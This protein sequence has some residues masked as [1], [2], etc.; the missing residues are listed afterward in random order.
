MDT[1]RSLHRK[2]NASAVVLVELG[3]GTQVWP[4]LASQADPSL[5]T[6]LI[7]QFG[8]SQVNPLILI[9]ELTIAEDDSIRQALILALGEYKTDILAPG[10]HLALIQKLL[11]LYREDPGP[12]THSAAEWLLRRWGK[13]EERKQIDAKM[14]S[15]GP[16]SGFQ[17][18]VN[19]HGQ[20]MVI[21]RGPV[22]RSFGGKEDTREVRIP[23]SF[24]LATKEVTR[25]QYGQYLNATAAG[26]SE[27]GRGDRPIG[28]R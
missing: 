11:A 9:H 16:R 12:G 6:R 4:L 22:K 8:P 25:E 13:D 23:R 28:P 7:H 19:K 2:A 3:E 21:V 24:A 15:D 26:E 27:Q 17:W 5:R 14:G 1:S 18:Y 10:V 20:T